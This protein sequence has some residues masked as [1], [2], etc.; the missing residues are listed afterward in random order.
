MLLAATLATL[1]SQAA[2]AMADVARAADGNTNPKMAV[3]DFQT[4]AGNESLAAMMAG[5]VATEIDRT[6]LFVVTTSDQVRALLSLDRQRQLLGCNDDSCNSNIAEQLG[7]DFMVNGRLTRLTDATKATTGLTLDLA[8]IDTKT[9]KRVSSREVKGTSEADLVSKLTENVAALIA[10]LLT[11]RQGFI[12]VIA[13]E[14]GSVVKIDGTQLGTTPMTQRLQVP[15]GPHVLRIEKEGFTSVQKQVRVAPDQVTEEAVRL[16]PSP[17]FIEGYEKKQW[18]LRIGAFIAVGVAVAGIATFG[19]MQ[20]Q[21]QASYGTGR[22]DSTETFLKL[23]ESLVADGENAEVRKK[24]ED[25]RNT[26]NSQLAISYVAG[27]LGLAGAI[28]ATVLFLI[29]ED[30]N[31]YQSY[32]GPKATAW[33][34]P[35]GAGG[36]LSW[37]F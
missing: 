7:V 32:R 16:M 29:G 26:I 15:G 23:R 3:P 31:K 21:A 5:S 30:P 18:G 17:D 14:D 24:A 27:G 36:A 4:S 34:L 19:I 13:S 2:P 12:V 6:G 10:P 9:G 37:D 11:G 8:I 33:L 20:G 28:T 25:L 35:T 1:L 22:S